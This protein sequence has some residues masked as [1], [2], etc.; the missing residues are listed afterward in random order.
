[1][2]TAGLDILLSA[3]GQSLQKTLAQAEKDLKSFTDELKRTSN[4]DAL[5]AVNKKIEVTKKQIQDIKAIGAGTFDKYNKSANTAIQTTTNLGRVVQDAPYGF[6]GIANNLNPL[7]EGFQRLKAETGSTKLAFKSLGQSLLGA[8]GIGIAV[9]LASAALVLFGDKLFGASKAAK[10]AEDEVKKFKETVEGIA[11]SI[12]KEASA[13]A[14]LVA[15]LSNE[16]ETRQRKIDALK[17]LK[18]LQPEIF[19]GLKLEGDQVVGLTSAY[20]KY[21]KSLSLV[22]AAK[23][24]QA[25]L[26][27]ILTDI[28]EAEGATL[29]K[30][31]KDNVKVLRDIVGNIGKT[32]QSGNLTL[33]AKRL[34]KEEVELN[35]KYKDRDALMKDLI[36]LSKGLEVQTKKATKTGGNQMQDLINKAKQLAAYLQER[37]IREVN[38]DVDP[39]ESLRTT[40]ERAKAFIDS[41]TNRFTEDFRYKINAFVEVE[42]VVL[43]KSSKY[44]AS[45]AKEALE[46]KKDLEK[47]IAELT[48]R[49]PILIQSAQF[50]AEA[51]NRRVEL[52]GALGAQ[53]EGVNSP[54]SLLSDVQKQAVNTANT[55]SNILTPA[56]DAF[57]QAVGRGESPLKAFFKAIQQAVLQLISQLIQAAIR[58]LIVKAIFSAASGGSGATFG[59]LFKSFA[60]FREGGGPVNGG[61]AYIVGEN[62]PELFQPTGSGRI[63]PNDQ[64]GGGI[65]GVTA[66]RQTVHV[67]AQISGR[68]LRLVN[69]RQQGYEGRNV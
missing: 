33:G 63:I 66:G 12:G 32:D 53:V 49:N 43:E 16:T 38:F 28:L 52:L 11:S 65:A 3:D 35:N 24:K 36:E 68:N 34:Q 7:L 13:V 57:V 64:L 67:V 2:A 22:L 61:N 56:F 47:Q 6:I 1:L 42:N 41:A 58:A 23:I 46:L 51:S 29:T 69:A 4:V 60:G 15:V 37:T 48:K 21:L 59:Q 9:S 44:F 14:G 10:K 62:G 27:K 55:V 18:D 54:V 40:F 17:Q 39:R 19:N 45:L 8:G 30:T 26:E 31:Q 25:Q 20:D 50:K 5:Q